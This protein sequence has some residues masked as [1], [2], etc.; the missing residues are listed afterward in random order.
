VRSSGPPGRLPLTPLFKPLIWTSFNIIWKSHV[1]KSHSL[2]E[3][4]WSKSSSTG[5]FNWPMAIETQRPI[6]NGSHYSL[7]THAKPYSVGSGHRTWFSVPSHCL[8]PVGGRTTP[9]NQVRLAS[10]SGTS[11]GSHYSLATHA[12]PYSVGSGYRTWFSDLIA[13]A[14]R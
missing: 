14:R 1:W 3:H 5:Q 12:K 10:S 4:A 6:S 13:F 11:N 7:A 2:L 8:L 9:S